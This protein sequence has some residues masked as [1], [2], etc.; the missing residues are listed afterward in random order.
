MTA[1]AGLANAGKALWKAVGEGLPDGW[2]LDERE[3]TILALAARQMDQV[4]SLERLVKKN[5]LMVKGSTGQPVLNPAIAEARQG[6]LAIGK[7]LGQ[8]AL[9]D[10]EGKPSTERQARARRAAES[11]WKAAS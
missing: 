9:P 3:Q 8:L 10:E 4:A 7:L 1:P 11:R 2:E 5:G 6:R